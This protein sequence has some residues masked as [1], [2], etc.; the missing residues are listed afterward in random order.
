M[1]VTFMSW[2]QVGS[3]ENSTYHPQCTAHMHPFCVVSHSCTAK[4]KN[5]TK[6]PTKKTKHACVVE[7]HACV[8]DVVEDH[9]ADASSDENSF[10][11]SSGG[12]VMGEARKV[13]S[14]ALE[15]GKDQKRRSFWKHKERKITSTLQHLWTSILSKMQS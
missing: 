4:R 2:A 12:Q 3:R 8:T 9:I 5:P 14:V 7:E 1:T 13:A 6:S 15:Q 11:K 10:S